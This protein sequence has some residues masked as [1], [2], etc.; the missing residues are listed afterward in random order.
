[1]EEAFQ[2]KNC[3]YWGY[4]IDK[5]SKNC[6]LLGNL[7]ETSWQSW[8]GWVKSMPFNLGYLGKFHQIDFV[9]TAITATVTAITIIAI[10]EREYLRFELS[11]FVRFKLAQVK[12][13]RVIIWLSQYE[14]AAVMFKLVI[15]MA[16]LEYSSKKDS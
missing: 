4:L 13:K 3:L 10:E 9:V 14:K 15:T 1:M 7:L 2:E 8:A 16:G 5:A 11:D 12:T 6:Y